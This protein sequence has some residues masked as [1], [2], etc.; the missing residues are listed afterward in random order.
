MCQIITVHVHIT[1]FDTLNSKKFHIFLNIYLL[2]VLLNFCFIRRIK[3]LRLLLKFYTEFEMLLFVTSGTNF[4]HKFRIVFN[5]PLQMLSF[6]LNQ[7]GR[8]SFCKRN[9]EFISKPFT[10]WP[11]Q[12]MFRQVT[13]YRYDRLL[14][15]I[16]WRDVFSSVADILRF[17]MSSTATAVYKTWNW[18]RMFTTTVCIM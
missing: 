1:Y 7:I 14:K 11:L 8:I 15:P 18:N 9:I 10:T 13:M 2:V 4:F 17:W 12:F 5:M 3:H 6:S 16:T